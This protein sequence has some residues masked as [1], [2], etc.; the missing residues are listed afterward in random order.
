MELPT[1][2]RKPISLNPHTILLYS[3]PKVGKTT[4]VSQLTNSLLIEHEPHGADFVE[5]NVIEINAPSELRELFLAV[6]TAGN[7]YKYL[8]VDTISKWDEWSELSGTLDYMGKAQGKKFNR[9]PDGKTIPMNNK[10]F[11]TV[12]EIPNGYG[13][14]YSRQVMQDW[15]DEITLLADHIIFLAHMK[16]KLIESKKTGDTVEAIDINLTGKVKTI[17]TSRVDAVGYLY[18]KGNQGI[19]NFNNENSV[20][21]G[22][23]CPHLDGEIVISEKLEDGTIKTFWNKIYLPE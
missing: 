20:T 8:I 18:K 4:I 22:G 15:F 7:P 21:C 9:T 2:K 23:R 17:Y 16:D 10:K 5:A 3:K 14:R 13:Y 12:H 1:Q 19:I 11:E 6:K